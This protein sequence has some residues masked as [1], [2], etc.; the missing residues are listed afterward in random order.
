MRLNSLFQR[1]GVRGI[2]EK[3]DYCAVDRLFPIIGAYIDLVT[4]FQT[5]VNMAGVL[6]M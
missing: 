4:E 1:C 6:L 3:I 5:E 2:L